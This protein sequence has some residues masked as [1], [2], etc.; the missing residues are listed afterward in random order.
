MARETRFKE[1]QCQSIGIIFRR[2]LHQC[3]QMVL[4]CK[5]TCTDLEDHSKLMLY[6]LVMKDPPYLTWGVQQVKRCNILIS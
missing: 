6:V 1:R 2:Y 4:P 3:M 5:V